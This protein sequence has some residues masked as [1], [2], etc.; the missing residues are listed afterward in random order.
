MS[1]CH[2]AQVNIAHLK[3]RFGDPEVAEFFENVP[4]VNALAESSPGFIWRYEGDYPDPMIAFNMSVWDSILHLS[5]FVYRSAHVNVLRR[6]DE[7]MT[8]IK[9]AHSALWWVKSGTLPTVEQ[10]LEALA[11]LDERGPTQA[12]FTF[13]TRFAEPQ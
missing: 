7:W 12:A 10:G 2:L 6:K 9:S 13:D 11:I 8:P 3:A 5:Q 1:E 4:R